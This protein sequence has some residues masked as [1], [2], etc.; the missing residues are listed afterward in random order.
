MFL[1]PQFISRGYAFGKSDGSVLSDDMNERD[2]T[3]IS[4]CAYSKVCISDFD[5][6]TDATMLLFVIK[7]RLGYEELE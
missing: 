5:I 6:V 4:L 7:R 2:S 3:Y 1:L